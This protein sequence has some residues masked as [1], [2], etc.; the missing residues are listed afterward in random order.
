MSNLT[1]HLLFETVTITASFL[2]EL[3]NL[4][5]AGPRHAREAAPSRGYLGDHGVGEAWYARLYVGQERR[6]DH[7]PRLREL[8]G[9][10]A[11]LLRRTGRKERPLGHGIDAPHEL[12]AL[13]GELV[14]C[15]VVELRS[16][17]ATDHLVELIETRCRRRV[18][19]NLVRA[20]W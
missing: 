6:L 13:G 5:Q 2:V 8:G 7:G 11:G 12:G 14:A 18:L 17:L 19:C 4:P 15:A 16:E 3:G 10:L 1:E 20:G 9:L